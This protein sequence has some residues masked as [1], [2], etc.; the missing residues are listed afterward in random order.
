MYYRIK[1]DPIPN[2][3][4][5]TNKIDTSSTNSFIKVGSG[6]Y[7]NNKTGQIG[8]LSIYYI[9]VG[10]VGELLIRFDT[11]QIQATFPQTNKAEAGAVFGAPSGD[12]TQGQ[13]LFLGEGYIEIYY[14]IEYPIA[15]WN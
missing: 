7:V 1:I 13:T 4:I 9:N 15:S 5:D 6:N 10:F 8:I 3:E 11:Q 12:T 14:N 2:L